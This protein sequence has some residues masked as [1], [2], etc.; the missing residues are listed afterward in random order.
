M[1]GFGLRLRLERLRLNM[2]QRDF[3]SAGGVFLN[4]QALYENGGRMPN[5]RYL[6]KIAAAGADIY[7]LF[8]GKRH[9]VQEHSESELTLIA[10]IRALAPPDRDAVVTVLLSIATKAQ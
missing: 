2:N 4:T 1:N 3:G 5:A 6:K 9:A 10:N 7:F 8:S